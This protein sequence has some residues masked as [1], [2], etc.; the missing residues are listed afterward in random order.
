MADRL[1]HPAPAL[2]SLRDSVNHEFP[3]RDK[4]SDGILGD[5]AHAARQS[6]HNPDYTKT[7]TRY[8]E[9]R[10][11]DIDIDDGDTGRDLRRELLNSL[12]GNPAVW[13]CISNGIIYSRTHNWAALKYTGTN[14]H[15]EHVHFSLVDSATAVNY[16]LKLK[17][18]SLPPTGG[19]QGEPKSQDPLGN[20]DAIL[21]MFCINRIR[22]AQPV[23]GECMG[24]GRRIMAV[25]RIL[26]PGAAKQLEIDWYSARVGQ[27]L[28]AQR[29]DTVAVGQH[30]RHQAALFMSAIQVIQGTGRLTPDGVVGP[31]TQAYMKTFGYRFKTQ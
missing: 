22:S 5:P 10:A 31:K 8:G 11:E 6:E 18:R 19:E 15:F 14:G 24:D 4:S 1:W 9:V 21:S 27:S 28:A 17:T 3:H 25:A 20:G 26:N 23:S 30:L 7:G 16:P 13:Y 2:L 29:G 12:I